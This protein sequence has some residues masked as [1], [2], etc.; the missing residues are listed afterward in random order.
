MSSV[1]AYRRHRR[2]ALFLLTALAAALTV[3]PDAVNMLA[4]AVPLWGLYELGILLCRLTSRPTTANE[5]D[6]RE[7]LEV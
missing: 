6:G 5:A 4:L 2:L 7:I 1:G 3:T